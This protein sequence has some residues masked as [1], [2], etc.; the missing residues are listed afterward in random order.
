MPDQQP[1]LRAA[2]EEQARAWAAWA[3]T[4][5]HDHFFERYN[6]PCFLELV[7][8]PQELT[9]EVGCGEG[10]VARALAARGHRV[11]GVDGSP[12]LT[13][14]AATHD[15]PT[16][17]VVGDAA[18]LPLHD[19]GADLVVAFMSLQDVDE[20]DAS[21]HE[22]ARVLR[23]GGAFCMAVLH[24]IVT[25]GD[26][27]DDTPSSAYVISRPYAEVRRFAEREERDGLAMVFHSVHRPLG[28]YI[29][30]LHRAGLVLEELREPLPPPALLADR[31]EMVRQAR[32]PWWLHVRARRPR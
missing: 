30:A 17:G 14:L 12:T 23:K 32:I 1:S 27:A 11:V 31:P 2:W 24:P 20:L 3:R 19:V 13:E 9:V 25:A 5:G 26:F 22:I 21:V 15:R 7:P 10:R 8:A 29:A 4:P 6:L 16:V 18:A 28:H